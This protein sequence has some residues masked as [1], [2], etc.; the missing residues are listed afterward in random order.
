ME[1]CAYAPIREAMIAAL[2]ICTSGLS[3]KDYDLACES[4]ECFEEDFSEGDTVAMIADAALF[5]RPPSARGRRMRK[6][7]I[8]RLTPKAFKDADP[9]VAAIGAKLPLAVFS[10]FEVEAVSISGE[11]KLRDLLDDDRV[12][13]GM[14]LSL[15][16]CARAGMLIAGRFVDVGQWHIA[17][18]IIVTLKKSEMLAISLGLSVFDDLESKREAL[19]PLVYHARIHGAPLALTAVSPL[20]EF[21]AAAVDAGAIDVDEAL[22]GFAGQAGPLLFD[23][24]W[25]ICF[26]FKDGDAWDVEIVD[27]H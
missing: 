7:P 14:D 5:L 15:A 10:M 19:C 8:D 25:R 3:A 4:L 2:Q 1:T 9:L 18:G 24:P 11:I 17:F 20:I 26:R 12:L 22:A 21:I 23:G 16:K 13:K 27:Y 6:R